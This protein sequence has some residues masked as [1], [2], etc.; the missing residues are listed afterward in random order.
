MRAVENQ[1]R[2]HICAESPGPL[3][4]ALKRRKRRDVDEGSVKFY[5][6]VQES[7]V[8]NTYASSE[9]LKRMDVDEDSV[10]F[11]KP[12][13]ESLVLNAYMRVVLDPAPTFC[14]KSL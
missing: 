6:P 12:V 13:Q 2:L 14:S 4:I 8:L 10:K 7:L 1:A 11:Y 5:K 9:S 3:Q